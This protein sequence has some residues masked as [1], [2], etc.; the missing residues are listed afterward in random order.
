[1]QAIITKFL[2]A[3]NSSGSRIK[4]SCDAGTVT[5]DYPYEANWGAEAHA[6]AVRALLAKLGWAGS[7]RMGCAPQKGCNVA[8]VAVCLDDKCPV[9]VQ[10]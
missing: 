5:V 7:W 4:A 9:D 2:P 8:Y 3:T 1:M 10:G 6:V